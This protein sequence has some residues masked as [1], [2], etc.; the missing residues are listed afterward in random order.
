MIAKILANKGFSA[1]QLA[2]MAPVIMN[3]RT[4]VDDINAL[5]NPTMSVEE[6]EEKL[7]AN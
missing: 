3:V 2:V 1:E 4:K 5:V 7:F 6:I